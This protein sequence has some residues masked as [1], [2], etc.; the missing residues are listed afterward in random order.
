MISFAPMAK[1]GDSLPPLCVDLDGTLIKTDLMWESVL[2]LLKGAPWKFVYL[3][4]WLARGKAH[5]KHKL[6]E[7]VDLDI[8]TLPYHQ[9]LIN[10]LEN[11]K[12]TDDRNIVLCTGS[13][14]S[15]ADDVSS[16]IQIFSEVLAT[17]NGQN[18][19]GND[20]ARLLEEKFGFR[21]FDYIGN[22]NKDRPVW[23]LARKALVVSKSPALVKAISED[24]DTEKVFPLKK[25]GLATYVRA[26]R[27]HQWV[28]NLLV[29][30]PFLLDHRIFDLAALGS[31]SLAF[32]CFCLIA[33]GTYIV[34]D[35]LD[36][37]SDRTHHKKC[38]RPFASGE[39]SVLTGIGL[40]SLLI[41]AGLLLAIIFL[42]PLFVAVML[43]YL[44][45]TLLYSFRFKTTPI[46]D[47][48]MLAGL[49]TIRVIAGTVAI[50]ALWSFWL[51]AFS[52]FIFL[53]LALAKRSSELYNLMQQDKHWANGRG[54]GI[55]D[56]PLINS[57]GIASGYLSVLVVALYINSEKVLSVYQHPEVLWIFCPALLYW[58]S[59]IWLKTSRGEMDEDPI[60]FA[61]KDRISWFIAA[62]CGATVTLALLLTRIDWNA[63]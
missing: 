21:G 44:V 40:L 58:I 26:L 41:G 11:Q 12:S 17:E 48:C 28:K 1:S 51:L 20:K 37:E 54:Y 4:F 47:V 62:I 57:M 34:N 49:Y 45:C 7:S 24:Y 27:L 14:R 38:K 13:H 22:E 61:I 6:A 2:K 60:V 25:P 8:S 36:L 55:D 46:L 63:F 5:I 32:L 53:S 3:P 30:I 33:S 31:T 50:T 16:H 42:P 18:I 39:L 19:T 52:I 23:S 35:L 59:R 43:A 56:L 9:E 29:F 15:L 10:Y